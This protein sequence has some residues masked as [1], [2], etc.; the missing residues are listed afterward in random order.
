MLSERNM[1]LHSPDAYCED[2][3]RNVGKLLKAPDSINKIRKGG[4]T[5]LHR[6]CYNGNAA[7][8]R[9]LIDS[10]ADA[11]A[12]DHKANTP[13]HVASSQGCLDAVR[14]LAGK[15]EESCTTNAAG[16]SDVSRSID[17]KEAGG[18][19]QVDGTR[20]LINLTNLAFQTALD[21]AKEAGQVEVVDFL[22]E[23]GAGS[24]DLLSACSH[25]NVD[26]VV[27]AIQSSKTASIDVNVR[28]IRGLLT[29]LHYST[30][31]VD[32]VRLLCD[33]G[34]DP[35]LS[36]ESGNT[37]LHFL[38]ESEDSKDV[39]ETLVKNGARVNA[40]NCQGKTPLHHA[41]IKLQPQVIECLLQTG[42]DGNSTDN[43]GATALHYLTLYNNIDSE[44]FI[45]VL[46]EIIDRELGY[47]NGY[48]KYL[49]NKRDELDYFVCRI[50]TADGYQMINACVRRKLDT[51]M[52]KCKLS[53]EDI[54][55]DDIA[56]R[57]EAD[58]EEHLKALELILH[59]WNITDSKDR[60]GRTS[61]HIAA[62]N[63]HLEIAKCLLEKHNA[64]ICA[65]DIYG[66]TV[67]H[68]AVANGHMDMTRLILQ[69]AETEQCKD[70]LLNCKEQYRGYT[71][72][73]RA[74]QSSH[75]DIADELLANKAD[76]NAPD[77]MQYT[78]LHTAIEK[79]EFQL[80][81]KLLLAGAD[82]NV[83][84]AVGN[85]PLHQ[86]ASQPTSE[87][88]TEIVRLLHSTYGADV[89]RQN[90]VGRTALHFAVRRDKKNRIRL[91]CELGA[92]ADIAD[93]Y[94]NTPLHI[95]DYM[96]PDT[97]EILVRHGASINAQNDSG[98]SP[99]H[100]AC[101]THR[102]VAC[103]NKLLEYGAKCSIVDAFGATPLH[104][105]CCHQTRYEVSEYLSLVRVLLEHG[106]DVN[107]RTK[108]SGKT[109]LHLAVENA[110]LCPK[111]LLA[112]IKRTDWSTADALGNSM[113]H[114]ILS[115]RSPQSTDGIIKKLNHSLPMNFCGLTCL[116]MN[117]KANLSDWMDGALNE[118]A[119]TQDRLGRTC[120]HL[121][122]SRGIAVT[123]SFSDKLNLLYATDFLQRN[124]F[125][126]VCIACP[127]HIKRDTVEFSLCSSE[128]S[129]L[130]RD[131][132][133]LV[134]ARDIYGR[135]PVFY[136]AVYQNELFVSQLISGGGDPNLADN[137]DVSPQH[138]ITAHKTDA[139]C[140]NARVIIRDCDQEN[141]NAQ[142]NEAYTLPD[143]TYKVWESLQPILVNESYNR[144]L[145]QKVNEFVCRLMNKVADL[146]PLFK[147]TPTLVGSAL[148]GT[149]AVRATDEFDYMIVLDN[150][151]NL[152]DYSARHECFPTPTYIRLKQSDDAQCIY[153]NYTGATSAVQP[154]L[155]KE[156]FYSLLIQACY[157]PDVWKDSPFEYL[158]TK[159]VNRMHSSAVPVKLSLNR[160]IDDQQQV[161]FYSRH[162]TQISIDLVPVVATKLELPSDTDFGSCVKQQGNIDCRGFAVVKPQ[163]Y[164]IGNE[165]DGFCPVVFIFPESAVISQS[166][167][168]KAAYTV[169][170]WLLFRD[171]EREIGIYKYAM[172]TCVIH[173]VVSKRFR[174][175]ALHEVNEDNLVHCIRVILQ[176]LWKCVE[177]D[178]VQNLMNPDQHLPIWKFE[179][180]AGFMSAYVSRYGLQY[181]SDLSDPDF[182]YDVGT[183]SKN[184]V[185][186]DMELSQH[187][188]RGRSRKLITQLRDGYRNMQKI[189][190][191]F[192]V[193]TS[194][195]NNEL[196]TC[197]GNIPELMQRNIVQFTIK[198]DDYTNKF[199]VNEI[200]KALLM[201][202]PH[203]FT[204]D[205]QH[206]Y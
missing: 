64:D 40:R 54:S 174:E 205:M 36:D 135:T 175:E 150:F 195:N 156:R 33:Y 134:N 62:A 192:S 104:Y 87:E 179:P 115:H 161:H 203:H 125:H 108:V 163:K 110:Q 65:R 3:L 139:I 182:E 53:S 129:R 100:M 127:D 170:K 141:E 123:M 17:G 94:G 92:R 120:L 91:L 200:T 169:I 96:K 154:T 85:T 38:V 116:H 172:K 117:A 30:G 86:V 112:L 184:Q 18:P 46:V 21:L 52:M 16:I 8:V 43:S 14:Q 67:L 159:I 145:K 202:S 44:D 23:S 146:D 7:F 37:A 13:L 82:A 114:C 12:R 15:A 83:Q 113:S 56:D 5:L 177:E 181:A 185:P 160:L 2:D 144:I 103:V 26:K 168:V 1:L 11:T 35:T 98:M 189:C 180:F 190:E 201:E 151:S 101:L 34:A 188:L 9:L 102:R 124:C 80:A 79:H 47:V 88:A 138:I 48:S 152:L 71:P 99:L 118:F 164:S 119:A 193:P 166:V 84:N 183:I 69:K 39:I 153:Q 81:A 199:Y 74:V 137:D 147:S 55:Q 75:C 72:L 90:H 206:Q 143:D 130:I 60:S 32:T 186:C 41:S 136:A 29:P 58:S 57:W 45:R 6:A 197:S 51:K 148:E 126:H 25:K 42:A 10:G 109:P 128:L 111:T 97:V 24:G 61:L 105:A 149:R 50:L 63:G 73:H 27:A 28:S 131:H 140:T 95:M 70:K 162:S 191:M 167:T 4:N 178:G 78:P 194:D 198:Y 204:F 176:Q 93:D 76:V 171:E 66:T 122:F 196:E 158:R 49:K 20:S 165:A 59:T 68:E 132:P 187:V 121:H 157:H 19:K 107:M 142:M 155:V 31:S 173:C 106:A 133:D 22:I 89:N 77:S